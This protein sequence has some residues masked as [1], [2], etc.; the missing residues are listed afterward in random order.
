VHLERI[1]KKLLS[2]TLDAALALM[3]VSIYLYIGIENISL[4]WWGNGL[5]GVL[6]HCK[7][8]TIEGYP[9]HK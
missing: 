6:P 9:V 5:D 1:K 2:G 4:D 7:G 3:V 8:I